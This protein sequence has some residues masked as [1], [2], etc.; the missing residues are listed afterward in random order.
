MPPPVDASILDAGAPT[1]ST[2]RSS[3]V[4]S[5]KTTH[6][7]TLL[8]A[9]STR[10]ACVWLPTR[11]AG[12][13]WATAPRRRSSFQ[14][15]TRR[16]PRSTSLHVIVG[17]PDTFQ[18]SYVTRTEKRDSGVPAGWYDNAPYRHVCG[19]LPDR[20]VAMAY[21]RSAMSTRMTRSDKGGP[22]PGEQLRAAQLRLID[23]SDNGKAG[24]LYGNFALVCGLSSA[25]IGSEERQFLVVPLPQQDVRCPPGAT[26]PLGCQI[27]HLLMAAAGPDRPPHT[28]GAS[29]AESR[30]VPNVRPVCPRPTGG[31]C[32]SA[33]RPTRPRSASGSPGLV[34][35]AQ[36]DRL[37]W[38]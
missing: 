30:A 36:R 21:R 23:S 28:P 25:P 6:S 15:R 38:R 4:T 2:A 29:P 5:F 11:A 3:P 8:P 37:A 33:A 10:S 14:G 1:S 20:S 26:A 34:R 31:R 16:R 24:R 19:S 7:R 27:E 17:S 35:L 32:A 18:L 13:P 22:L 9:G 12:S